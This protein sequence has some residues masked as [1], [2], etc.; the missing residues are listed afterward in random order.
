MCPP[1]PKL[2]NRIADTNTVLASSSMSCPPGTVG[3]QIRWANASQNL[4][5]AVGGVTSFPRF[6]EAQSKP[7]SAAGL[8]LE[9]RGRPVFLLECGF[10]AIFSFL[11]RE[12]EKRYGDDQS[13]H[14]SSTTQHAQ[15]SRKGRVS[16]ETQEKSST[17]AWRRDYHELPLRHR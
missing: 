2:D 12:R 14:S 15:S 13:T 1:S 17:G 6:F 4:A 3:K 11:E 16:P 9:P 5:C 10:A 8:V 7:L